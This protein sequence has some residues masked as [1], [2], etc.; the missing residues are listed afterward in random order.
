MGITPLHTIA[1]AGNVSFARLL[2]DAG[3]DVNAPV[4]NIYY[5]NE[6]GT[7]LPFAIF[8]KQADMVELLLQ[9][10]ADLAALVG[11]Q[12]LLSPADFN[13]R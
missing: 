6:L 8:H 10:G 2:I 13:H 1:H 9:A 11:R 5:V 12:Y 3:A 7:A 4:R